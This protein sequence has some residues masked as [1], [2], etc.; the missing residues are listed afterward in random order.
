MMPPP[1]GP[2]HAVFLDIDGTLIDLAATP[3][4]VVVPP[5]LPHTLAALRA[6]LGGAVALLTGRR[7]ADV[8]RLIGP[9]YA[10][11][12][13]HGGIL[14]DA[15]GTVTYTARRPAKYDVWLK[16]LNARAAEMPG[17]LVEVKEFNLVVHFRLAPECEAEVRRLVEG[18]VA[19]A[20]DVVLLP[21]HC[22]FELKAR[23]GNKGSALLHFMQTPPFAGRIPLFVGD[24][25]TDEPAMAQADALGG[26]GLHVARDFGDST[27]AVREW[28]RQN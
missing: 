8:D 21:A 10:A 13:E 16:L 19:D 15:G 22:A 1:I 27:Q 3:D 5:E 7:L 9:D 23:G 6:Q 17:V 12:A 26:A 14:R 18:L 28:L 25:I 4:A 24:D 2:Q 11:A 20:D